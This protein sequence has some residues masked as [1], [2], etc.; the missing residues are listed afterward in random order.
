MLFN[1][2]PLPP[3]DGGRVIAAVFTRNPQLWFAKYDRAG[4]MILLALLFLPA[5]FGYN[6]ASDMLEVPVLWTISQILL[7]TGNDLAMLK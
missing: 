1:L 6:L 5:L 3:L 4:M 7:F 2:I